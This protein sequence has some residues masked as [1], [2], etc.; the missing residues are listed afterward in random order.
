MR[1]VVSLRARILQTRTVPA[2]EGVGYNATWIASRASRIATVSAGYADGYSRALSGRGLARF[3]G[4]PAPLVGRVSM[5]LTTFDV[6]GLDV[7]A[8]DWLDLIGHGVTTDDVA[9]RAG[10]N[11]YEI[12][13]QLG[14]RY[15]R[16]V[17]PA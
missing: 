14:G 3:D 1:P 5:D 6:T 16:S 15:A 17:L 7:S 13:T 11:G 8:G 12:L 9:A 2:G 10:T 4:H